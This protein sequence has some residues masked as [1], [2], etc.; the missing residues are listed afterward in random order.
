[1]VNGQRTAQMTKDGNDIQNMEN[2]GDNSFLLG[3]IIWI[4]GGNEFCCRHPPISRMA[5][6]TPL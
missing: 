1:M 2:S 4:C 5:S 3:K 6:R